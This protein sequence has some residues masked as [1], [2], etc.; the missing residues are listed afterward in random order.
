MST[1]KTRHIGELITDLAAHGL[2]APQ[3]SLHPVPVHSWGNDI[4]AVEIDARRYA[5]AE[6]QW[7]R[8]AQSLGFRF[9]YLPTA[10]KRTTCRATSGKR[11]DRGPA[12]ADLLV[13]GT[14]AGAGDARQP[15]WWPRSPIWRGSPAAGGQVR[16][17]V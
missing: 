1:P 17:L 3:V 7:L 15:V 6:A 8:L 14:P 5:A 4:S 16:R 13:L 11:R 2:A 10:P 12:G 9:A